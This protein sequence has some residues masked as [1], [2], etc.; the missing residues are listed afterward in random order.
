[1]CQDGLNGAG[2]TTKARARRLR[3]GWFDRYA[4][5]HMSGIDIGCQRDP[6]NHT[7]RRWDVIFGD[8]DAT[9]MA[10]VPDGRFQ[11]TYCSHVLEHVNSPVEALRNWH[12]ITRPGGNLI[13]LVPH[14]DLYEKKTDLPSRW[15]HEHKWYFLPEQSEP[16]VTLGFLPLILEAL[17]DAKVV[18][19]RVLDE[20]FVSTPPEQ[21]SVGE[22]SIEAV[23]QK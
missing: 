17:P 6:L 5:D 2:E 8:G 7:F 10:G 23:I 3:E 22:Y 14:R 4:P 1:M 20:G 12:R 19:F 9:F 21:H 16:P 13:V 15:N 18:S 11:T